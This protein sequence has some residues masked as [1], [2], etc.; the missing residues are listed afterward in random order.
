MAAATAA[1]ADRGP[2]PGPHAGR[3]AQAARFHRDPLGFLCDARD[4]FG[5]TF[6]LRLAVSG[7]MV[8]FT[9][10]AVIDEVVELPRDAATRARQDDGS[11]R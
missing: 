4:E 2:P 1:T 6:T 3:I 10:P 7:S 11:S 8:V 9:D 5:S